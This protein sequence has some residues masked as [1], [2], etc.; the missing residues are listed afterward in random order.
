MQL[1]L[2]GTL[3]EIKDT[4]QVT[5]TFKKRE[6]TIEY[7]EDS[8]YSEYLTFQLIQDRCDLMDNFQLNQKITVYFN[9]K[10]RK[11]INKEEITKYFNSL[12]AWKIEA[13]DNTKDNFATTENMEKTD[14]N[15][16]ENETKKN[17]DLPF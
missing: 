5:D 12:Q 2:T 8:Q 10:G 4:H 16:T 14:Q 1:N 9:L 17:D 7:I 3:Q 13:A 15:T 6:F 11:W